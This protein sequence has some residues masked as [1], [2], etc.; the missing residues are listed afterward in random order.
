MERVVELLGK[1]DLRQALVRLWVLG[2]EGQRLNQWEQAR[3]DDQTLDTE[4]LQFLSDL[5]NQTALSRDRIQAAPLALIRALDDYVAH[6]NSPY[7]TSARFDSATLTRYENGKDYWL[8]PVS[9][10]ARRNASLCKQPGNLAA[11]FHRHAVLP[12]TTAHGLRVTI[13]IS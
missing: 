8:V 10:Q 4:R 7:N 12:A 9:L 6:T 13:S 2:S 1:N 11:W 5:Q 3:S